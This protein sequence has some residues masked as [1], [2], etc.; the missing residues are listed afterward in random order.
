MS[1]EASCPTTMT[2]LR[3][4][5]ANL[6]LSEQTVNLLIDRMEQVFKLFSEKGDQL[7]QLIDELTLL[8]EGLTRSL[9]DSDAQ[10]NDLVT[11]TAAY[12]TELQLMRQEQEND[13][14]E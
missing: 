4:C 9:S 8:R 10:L 6:E 1:K 2:E 5:V 13:D 3:K 7:S 14:N 11:V 12:T